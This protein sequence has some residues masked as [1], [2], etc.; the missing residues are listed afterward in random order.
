[1]NKKVFLVIGTIITIIIT[2]FIIFFIDSKKVVTYKVTY[3]TNGGSLIETQTVKSNEKVIKPKDPTKEGYIFLEWTYQGVTYD[4]SK[5]VT[6]DLKLVAKWF[7]RQENIETFV[8]KF[9]TDGGTTISNQV[10]EKG[11]KIE[12][13]VIPTK[14]G[15][16]FIEWVYNN[17]TYDFD[18]A[19]E[20]D[21]VL[22]AIWKKIDELSDNSITNNKSNSN[23]NNKSNSNNNNNSNSKNNTVTR[24]T[25]TFDTNGG[26]YVESKTVDVGKTIKKPDNP[27]KNGYDFIGWN[28][29][30]NLFDFNSPINS[31]ITLTAVWSNQIWDIDSSTGSIV[32][33]KG[34]S[35]DITIPS[36]IDGVTIKKI[37]SNAFASS[38][39]KSVIIPPSITVIEN[40][41]FL[42]SS[43]KNLTKVYIKDS[44]WKSN[45]WNSIFG[46][47]G[48][49]YVTGDS[50]VLIKG[51]YLLEGCN[52]TPYSGTCA[53]SR[54]V[55]V[56]NSDGIYPIYLSINDCLKANNIKGIISVEIPYY[57][58]SDSYKVTSLG[59]K[60]FQGWI[61]DNGDTPQ[62]LVVI[63]AGSTGEK[64]YTAVC[65]K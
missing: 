31:N 32:K 28:L 22:K 64:H 53:V 49:S 24:Y 18:K 45:N 17:E 36:V 46:T 54:F 50:G 25:V 63:P 61:G 37:N 8:I 65:S 30:G 2:I 56:I 43:N 51:E 6:S 29:N 52:R 20:E 38:I 48:V 19:V 62:N 40:S 59:Y 57:V 41:A 33:Y 14:E 1:M 9:E 47:S 26:T 5:D 16:T 39:L 12:K 7:K 42:K 15:Y 60:N 10:V 27:S 23:V 11:K 55:E 4:F 44:L 13:P 58:T 3:D 35:S 34:T 21:L